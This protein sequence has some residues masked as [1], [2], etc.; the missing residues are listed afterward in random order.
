MRG[1]VFF[2]SPCL[3]MG[4]SAFPH[5]AHLVLARVYRNSNAGLSRRRE[6][7]VL[8]VEW[9]L[10]P[11]HLCHLSALLFFVVGECVSVAPMVLSVRSC[12]PPSICF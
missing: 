5:A 11:W 6:E 12:F 9:F 3:C 1:A 4:G 8:W 10:S 2:V 7:G